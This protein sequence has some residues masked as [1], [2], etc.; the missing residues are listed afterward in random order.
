MRPIAEYVELACCFHLGL[1]EMPVEGILSRMLDCIGPGDA[2]AAERIQAD[3]LEMERVTPGVLDTGWSLLAPKAGKVPGLNQGIVEFATFPTGT[4]WFFS[5]DPSRDM[6]R[7]ICRV[8]LAV[9]VLP[10]DPA[11]G[12]RMTAWLAGRLTRQKVKECA[13]ARS[14][15]QFIEM[16]LSETTRPCRRRHLR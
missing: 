15:R 3:C 14:R 9:L 7:G 4:R 10:I 6:G 2:S 12:L 1:P 16:L 13:Q 11:E 5:S 8:R